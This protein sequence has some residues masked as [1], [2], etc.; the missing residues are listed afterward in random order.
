[1]VWH[2]EGSGRFS[3]CSAYKLACISAAASTSGSTARNWRF[4]WR[5]RVPP[6]VRL[7][8]WKVCKN[9]LPTMCNLRK[10]GVE[11]KEGCVLCDAETESVMH[12]L[13][14]CPFPRLD[15]ALSTLPWL[16][17]SNYESRME[18]GYGVCTVSLLVRT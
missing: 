8:V 15:L 7:F 3:V 2:Y 14:L 5:A 13:I 9:A 17:I 16:V 12:T 4:I 6:K 10:R 18:D 11:V 1:M